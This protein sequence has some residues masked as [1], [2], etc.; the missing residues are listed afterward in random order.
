MREYK[1]TGRIITESGVWTTCQFVLFVSSTGE[2]LLKCVC[3]DE[4]SLFQFLNEI[5][6]PK[7]IRC[8]FS[9]SLTDS[10]SHLTV[11]TILLNRSVLSQN[12]ELRAELEFY[13]LTPVLIEYQQITND[14]NVEYRFGLVNLLFTGKR[15]HLNIDGYHISL[16]LL[17]PLE[18][19]SKRLSKD[20]GTTIT[21]NL[22]AIATP[23]EENKVRKVCENLCVLLSFAT[24]NW[25]TWVYEDC[26]QG[27]KLVRSRLPASKT[28]AYHHADT[29]IDTGSTKEL[30]AYLETV[31]PNY[32]EAKS[33]LGLDIVIE[34]YVHSKLT[35][36]IELRYLLATIGMECLKSH[37][38]SY[39]QS[40]NK[41]ADLGSF[42]K[43]LKALFEDI[44]MPY[45]QD[46]LEFIDL[47][48]Y[49][50]H[51]G[52]FP[53]NVNSVEKWLELINLY[54]R[55]VLTILGYRGKPYLNIAKGYA[56]ELL[57]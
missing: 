5:T 46:E 26:F 7:P 27:G 42:R 36:I 54:D 18:S 39:F 2:H 3:F 48:N 35:K 14:Q 52:R 1:G 20:G 33:S 22:N 23:A 34:Y 41:S 45:E 43:A 28:F 12:K 49:I 19:L 9:G 30:G 29:V 55:V 50:V 31:Y 13:P 16:H 25:I 53:S 37:L 15:I 4:C 11:D 17:A 10:D 51:T 56:K 32:I 21:A 6:W 38:S 57:P 47:R 44:S 8:S 24:G 40:K